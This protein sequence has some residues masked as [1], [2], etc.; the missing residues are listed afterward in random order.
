MSKI[1][2]NEPCPCGSGKKYKRCCLDNPERLS[3]P[4]AGTF[5]Y[6]TINRI[7][8]E[9]IIERLAAIGIDFDHNMFV[10]EIELSYTAGQ[11]AKR[12][13]RT[14]TA[15][16]PEGES[17]FIGHAVSV[18]WD[19]MAA[20]HNLPA[21]LMSRLIDRGVVCLRRKEYGAACDIWL[22]V[23]EAIKYK[24]K[25]GFTDLEPLDKEYSAFF[26]IR[27]L[28]QDL[29]EVLHNA[30]LGEHIY[31][32]KRIDYCRDFLDLFPNE[33]ELI[34][35]NMRRAVADSY[36]RLGNYEESE[37]EYHKLVADYPTNLWSYIGWGDI[38]FLDK[39]DN[40]DQARE[41]YLKAL[42][43]AR[44]SEEIEIAKER[45][46]DLEYKMRLE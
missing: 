16:S 28:C 14:S 15:D 22:E 20:P 11:I 35:H 43:T 33:N 32:E 46:Q 1:G 21:E 40:Y 12:W 5:T 6:E 41:L 39:K 42:D 25:P 9:K 45:L 10:K 26:S 8:S 24:H 27:N 23:W 31:F 7:A 19:R 34:V 38:Y 2:R 36:S 13:R 37:R 17:D 30:G 44:D 29:E 4:V 3:H 18:L